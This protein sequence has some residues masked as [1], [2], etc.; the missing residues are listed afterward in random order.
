MLLQTQVF[1]P[2]LSTSD[3]FFV[4]TMAASTTP[5]LYEKA[6]V[7][8]DLVTIQVGQYLATVYPNVEPS[9]PVY[10]CI[11]AFQVARTTLEPLPVNTRLILDAIGAQS[12]CSAII[13]SLMFD[14]NQLL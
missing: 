3:N 4:F 11:H 13:D 14:W 8:Q 5:S 7:P 2:P 1:T 6:F 9:M 10:E 12:N